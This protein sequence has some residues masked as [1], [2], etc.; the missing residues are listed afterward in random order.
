MSEMV[1]N[2]ELGKII[3]TILEEEA[4]L[5]SFVFFLNKLEN[6]NSSIDEIVRVFRDYLLLCKNEL[7]KGKKEYAH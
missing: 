1:N 5:Q 2:K 7:P 3:L 4:K 6:V